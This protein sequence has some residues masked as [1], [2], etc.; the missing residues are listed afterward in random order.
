MRVVD[1]DRPHP[2]RGEIVVK[3]AYTGICGTDIEI[4]TGR[5]PFIKLGLIPLPQ[6]LGH[7]WSGIVDE[8]GESVTEFAPGDR[9]T[10]DVT[11]SCRVCEFCKQG[12]YNICPNRRSVG[13]IRKDGAFAE[14]L[15]MPVHHVYKLPQ[16]LSLEEAAL[17]EPASCAVHGVRRM[18]VGPGDLIVVVGDGTIGLLALQAARAAGASKVVMIGSHDSKLA[19]ARQIGAE[20]TVNRHRDDVRQAPLDRLGGKAD[21]VVEASGNTAAVEPAL[22]L[23]RPGGRMVIISLYHEPVPTLDMAFVA[24]NEIVITGTLAG[25][26][27]FPGLLRLMADGIIRTKPLITHRLVLEHVPEAFQKIA[28]RA[29]PSVKMMVT[30]DG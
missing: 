18:G 3:I 4:Y 16:T 10:G 13:I 26:N 20:D 2:G 15:V 29:E 14:Y 24:A 21:G 7:E 17:A 23:L 30:Q 8:I 9:V 6:T 19:L 12:R 5:M 25:P 22:R 28:D 27:I 1:V 11:I